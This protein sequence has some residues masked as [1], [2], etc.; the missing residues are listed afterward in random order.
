MLFRS[1]VLSSDGTFNGLF[2]G[3]LLRVWK[4]GAFT[5]DYKKFRQAIVQ[6]M[7]P[8]QTPRYFV[9]GAPN[10]GFEA[11]KPFTI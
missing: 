9:V 11:Q 5:G 4:D 10:P 8:D 7:P 2:T 1:K 6:R 3:T